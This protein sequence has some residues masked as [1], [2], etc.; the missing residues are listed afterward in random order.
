MHQLMASCPML[1]TAH[2]MHASGAPTTLLPG[3]RKLDAVPENA[4]AEL[5]YRDYLQ[6]PLQPLQV[7]STPPRG[8]VGGGGS[9]ECSTPTWGRRTGWPPWRRTWPP[10]ICASPSS[11]ARNHLPCTSARTCRLPTNRPTAGQPGEPDVRDVRE[12][13]HEVRSVRGGG[14]HVPAGHGHGRGGAGGRVRVGV[15]D[16]GGTGGQHAQG[17]DGVWVGGLGDRPWPRPPWRCLGP[18]AHMNNQA[19]A[20]AA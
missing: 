18:G 9:L 7:R 4:R 17:K 16:V 6:A 11:A 15:W 12:G 10:F 20:H 1:H 2:R 13:P 5:E 14:T 3:R 19:H 8:A